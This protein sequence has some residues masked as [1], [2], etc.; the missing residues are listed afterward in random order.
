MKFTVIAAV[1]L[2][3]SATAVFAQNAS[4]GSTV[5][6]GDSAV[7]PATANPVGAPARGEGASMPGNGV[8]SGTSS[9]GTTGDTI[10]TGRG[11]T[12]TAAPRPSAPK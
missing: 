5:T 11:T 8:S 6:T 10:G 4:T 1:G 12:D 7:S 3:F 9:N 2:I